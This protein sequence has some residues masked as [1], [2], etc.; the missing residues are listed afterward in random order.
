MVL[1]HICRLHVAARIRNE[2]ANCFF[3]IYSSCIQVHPPPLLQPRTLRS[4]KLSYLAMD[5]LYNYQNRKSPSNSRPEL[6]DWCHN[7]AIRLVPKFYREAYVEDSRPFKDIKIS[8]RDGCQMCVLLC[9]G[10]SAL[11]GQLERNDCKIRTRLVPSLDKSHFTIEFRCSQVLNSSDVQS[12]RFRLFEFCSTTGNNNFH[13]L[14][15][16]NLRSH[17]RNAK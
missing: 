1:R 13:Y 4:S 8:A 16:T 15:I 11:V 12:K 14:L 5:L 7:R 3:N 9:A 10:V 17:R 6:C 2:L